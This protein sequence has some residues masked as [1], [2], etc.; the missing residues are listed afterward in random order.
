MCV[1]VKL[2]D[3]L[4]AGI[5]S[6]RWGQGIEIRE[7][8]AVRPCS[9]RYRLLWHLDLCVAVLMERWDDKD[10]RQEFRV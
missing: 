9:K 6:V 7:E 2:I 8:L 5:S 4:S 3:N 10:A 1:Y